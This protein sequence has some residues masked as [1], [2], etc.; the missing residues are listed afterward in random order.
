MRAKIQQ[1]LPLRVRSKLPEV[2]DLG[3]MTKSVYIDHITHQVELYCKKEQN[4]KDQAQ[5]ALRK[6]N[7]IQLV[8]NW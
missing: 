5:E 3:S 6:L 1:G 4:L 8:D 7:Q 2:V